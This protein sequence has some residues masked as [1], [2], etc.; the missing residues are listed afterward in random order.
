MKVF[1]AG[2]K[3]FT[4]AF[5]MIAELYNAYLEKC[6]GYYKE[7]GKE[8]SCYDKCRALTEIQVYNPEHENISLQVFR[9]MAG[10]IDKAFQSFFRQVKEKKGFPRFGRNGNSCAIEKDLVW[11]GFRQ[12]QEGVR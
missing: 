4:R 2:S 5:E 9:G 3:T 7:T 8:Y 11:L 1:K 10:R 6:V 12:N